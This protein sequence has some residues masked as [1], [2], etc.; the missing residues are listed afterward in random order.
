MFINYAI[1][2]K[3]KNVFFFSAPN[4][5]KSELLEYK[6]LEQDESFLYWK[7][8]HIISILFSLLEWLSSRNEKPYAFNTS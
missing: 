7:V 4:N 2:Y 6:S 3:E 1:L 8:I 5:L